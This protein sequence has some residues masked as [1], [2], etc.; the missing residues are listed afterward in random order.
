MATYEEIYGKRVKE[1]SADPTLDSS[2]EGQ[3]WYNST[4]GVLKSVVNFSAF[5]SGGTL[6][7]TR[8]Q[9]AGAGTK[10][11][12]LAMGG[13]PSSSTAPSRTNGNKTE[14]YNGF[15]YT[16]ES[17]SPL[18]KRQGSGL[19][20]QTAALFFGGY[21]DPQ[22]YEAT[23]AEFDGSSWTSGTSY[24]SD[25]ANGSG[26][27]AGTLTAGWNAGGYNGSTNVNTTFEYNGSSWTAGG[28]VGWSAS[29]MTNL[30]PLTAGITAGGNIP[31]IT[32]NVAFYDGTS[33]T[34]QPALS[35]PA[36]GNSQA[37]TQS[38]AILFGG[39]I[40]TASNSV[41]LEWDGSA[42]ATNPASLATARASGASCGVSTSINDGFMS[43]GD[44]SETTVYNSTEEFNK[45]IN[46]ITK[47]AWASAPSLGT[48]R[49]QVGGFGHTTTTAVCVCGQNPPALS[50]VEEYDGSS[51]SEVTNMPVARVK[52]F[53][54]G[55]LTAGLAGGGESGPTPTSAPSA[56]EYDGTNWTATPA[57]PQAATDS[58]SFGL[59]TA[60]VM[61]IGVPSP[62]T[63]VF[64]YNGSTWTAGTATPI[65]MASSSGNG[66]ETAGL[67]YTGA[68]LSTS[69]SLAYNGSSWT[70]A[71]ALIA[72]RSR[73][74]E[75]VGAP[76]TAALFF[77]GN[78]PTSTT[79]AE[80][81]GYDGTSWSTR[82]NM[83]TARRGLGG[84]GINTASLAFAGYT[85]TADTAVSEEF[86]GTTETVTA[87]TLTSS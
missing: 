42:W 29:N 8:S 57:I 23:A 19:G 83:A 40:T 21:D 36:T 65:Q 82:P 28:D 53:A 68:A 74:A 25:I 48:A 78:N 27:G 84:A 4:S 70:S 39:Y 15:V 62:T 59:Q 51:W 52:P 87:S 60:T 2:Y 13:T 3:V 73:S 6:N 76:S 35:Q 16:N 50:N 37:G 64:D 12:G 47:A 26:G 33:W 58:T 17:N 24:P 55:T 86:T 71:G 46:T 61:C 44:V 30:G 43:G 85:G 18:Y 5:I 80:T 63:A 9:I 1:L 67:V 81:Y 20:T 34:N 31:P 69:E 54:S 22:G 45:S 10:T 75:A 11:A 38:N 77:A 66:V 49:R 79:K 7:T 32:T 41:C 14:S 56:A 72:A